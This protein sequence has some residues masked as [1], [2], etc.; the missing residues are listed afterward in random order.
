MFKKMT[1]KLKLTV[2][3]IITAL[4]F[5]LLIMV[6]QNAIH[7]MHEV[8]LANGLVN[9][10]DVELLELEKLDKSFFRKKDMMY[11]EKFEKKMKKVIDIE[12]KIE[13]I[14]EEQDIHLE[15]LG[16]LF[17]QIEEYN[18]Q[19]K[20][21]VSQQQRTESNI[22]IELLN[23]LHAISEKALDIMHH[24]EEEMSIELD[25]I[26]EEIT[27]QNLCNAIIV[28][29]VIIIFI[30]IISKQVSVSISTFQ[31]GLKGF[32]DYINKKT[33]SVNNINADIKD[34]FGLMADMVNAN[35]EETKRSITE[36]RETIDATIKVLEDF[37]QGD[38]TK[39]V[40][41]NTTNESLKELNK[42]LNQMAIK[43]EDNINSVLTVLNQYSQYDYTHTVSQNNIK[44]HF[45]KLAQ[46]VN[47]LGKSTTDMLVENKSNGLTLDLSSDTLLKNVDVLNKN[48]NHAAAA[49]EETSAAL[50]EMTSSISS[51]TENVIKMSDFANKL[52]TSANEGQTLANETTSSM[53]EINEQ[54]SSINEAIKVIDQI[55]FQTNILSL[56]AA[57][58]AATAGEA[59]K[60]FAVVAQEVRNLAARSAEAANEIKSIVENATQKA[61]NGKKIAAKMIEGYT[62]LNTNINETLELITSVESASREQQSGII[63]IND[64]ITSLDK[65]TQENA[66]IASQT[67]NIA[68]ET[69]DIAKMVVAD[70]NEKNFIGKDKVQAKTKSKPKLATKKE[71][72]PP[73][74][75][76][77][78]KTSVVEETKQ[79]IQPKTTVKT[80]STNTIKPV[81]SDNSDDE[82]ASF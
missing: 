46:G 3:T 11:V 6:S 36:D 20:Q 14:S 76:M 69:D 2:L 15:D 16:P 57:V 56:N 10:L 5:I 17:K 29:L 26:T 1:V 47:T 80:V 61:S 59:G 70:A 41:T 53:D 81:V 82:W 51:N 67:Q 66:S 32:F 31:N 55:S 23:N 49:L 72:T 74:K 37:E 38:L 24:V 44:E 63:Q 62:G 45:L 68:S 79:V 64:A 30:F 4:G 18:V 40:K 54:V 28:M 22:D 35:I 27:F 12:H 34:E 77:K 52:S 42:V 43:M 33:T 71:I 58:E 65:Q 19:F 21:L 8:G 48:S 50:E 13:V 9:H 78:R 75:E 60:G 25:R 7:K 39:R 73:T